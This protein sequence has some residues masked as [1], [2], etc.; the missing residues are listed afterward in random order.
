MEF[1]SNILSGFPDKPLVSFVADNIILPDLL[2][3]DLELT[4]VFL[5]ERFIYGEAELFFCPQVDGNAFVIIS[6]NDDVAPISAF[7]YK[8]DKKWEKIQIHTLIHEYGIREILGVLGDYS[9]I[10]VV[11]DVFREG[12]TSVY[13][14]NLKTK[15][16]R[17]LG[18]KDIQQ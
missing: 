12:I 17:L 7:Y 9:R 2:K 13:S 11:V 10:W 3:N 15:T 8:E 6:N 5:S 18:S 16:T 1:L 4:K 14:Y